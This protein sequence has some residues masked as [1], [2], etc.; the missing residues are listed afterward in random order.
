MLTPR[1]GPVPAGMA[2]GGLVETERHGSSARPARIEALERVGG[3]LELVESARVE[4]DPPAAPLFIDGALLARQLQ[5]MAGQR[6]GGAAGRRA[7]DEEQQE[8]GE[9][10][11]PEYHDPVQH[12]L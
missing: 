12:A 8:Q 11:E 5:G 10:R 1:R 7:E 4:E 9:Q 6:R 2:E 3:R